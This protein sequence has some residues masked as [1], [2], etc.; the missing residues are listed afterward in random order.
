MTDP[1]CEPGLSWSTPPLPD[2]LRWY[3]MDGAGRL[4]LRGRCWDLAPG[5][6]IVFAPGDQPWASDDPRRRL[7]V[8]GVDFAG[9][10]GQPHLCELLTAHPKM[11]HHQGFWW[12]PGGGGRLPGGWIACAGSAGPH[13]NVPRSGRR[14]VGQSAERHRW[15]RR[16]AA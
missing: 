16:A 4:V 9:A 13:D 14:A 6:G 8:F 1:R 11:V 10:S 15:F 12:A 2:Y 7:L 5:A 3:V